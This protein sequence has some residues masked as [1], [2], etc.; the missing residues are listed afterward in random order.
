M[1]GR[2]AHPVLRRRRELAQQCRRSALRAAVGMALVLLMLAQTGTAA[3]D[4]S[5]LFVDRA[6]PNCSDA[7]SGTASQPFCT[8]G[9]AAQRVSAGQTVQVA[10]GSYSENVTVPTSGTATAPV[11]FTAA[12][13]ATVVLSGQASGFTISGRSWI[14]VTGFTVTG[15]SGYGISVTSSAHITL[16]GNH[17]SYSGH[18]VSG[19]T[20]SGIRL[21]NVTDSLVSRNTADHNTYA[22]IELNNGSTRNE[23]KDNVTFNNARGYE[24]A[25]PG[26]R[27][28][29]AP[30]NIVDGNVSHH[31]E[32]SG[33]EA[34]P[35][36][37]NSLIY[38]NVTYNNGDH[39]ID[40]LTCTGQRI[41]ANT[42]YKNVTAGIN[43]EGNSTGATLANNI[44]VDNGIKSP[45]THSDI[46]IEAGSTAGTTM[47]YDLVYLTTPDTILIWSSTSYSSLAA[48][49][50]ASGQE[51]HGIQADPRWAGPSAGD[52][53]LTAGSPAIDSANSGAS[54][55]PT[56]DTE[57]NARV[58]DPGTQNTGTGPRAYDDRGAY[59]L[60][61]SGPPP[62]AAPNA[63]LTVNPS[64]GVA[65]VQVTADASASTDEDATPI[66]TYTFDFGDGS[67]AVGPQAGATAT[68]T[69]TAPG[70]YTV[71]VTV[72]DTG[73]LS[74]TA[75]AGVAVSSS[76]AAPN[77]ALTVNPS[78]GAA[79]VQVTADA[80]AST[81]EDAT[82]IAT[83][84]FDFGDGS[85]AVGPQAGATA[86]H[87]YTAPGNYTA[88]VTVTDTGG[89]SSTATAQVAVT[90]DA[91]P[92]AA[93]TVTPGTGA[94]PLQV[95]ADA[96]ASRDGD[97]TPIATYT[98]DFGDGSPAVGP[99]A[100]AT[101][102]HTYTAPGNYTAT[103]T[104]TDT[105]GLSSTASAQ[106][107]VTGLNNL[108]GNPGFETDLSGWNTSGSGT[109]ISLARV[110][111]GHS[112][113]WAAMLTNAGSTASTCTLNDSPDWAK[114]T[115]A[116]TYTGSIWVRADTP[117]ATLKLRFR[118]YSGST[119][120]GTQ[121]TLA[122]LTTSWQQV[123]VAYTTQA[124]GSSTLDFNA[125]VSSAAP[126]S[127]FY[128]D[129]AEIYLG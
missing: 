94:A 103:V 106:V 116:G 44:S 64:T 38:N 23:V 24:R 28:Y 72:T 5:V 93:L 79:P 77:A 67:P 51:A 114:P 97:A 58:D 19:Q 21:G 112:G 54:G 111:G 17:V 29:A 85:P 2:R 60:Q 20:R 62:D 22:G 66:A 36:S 126:G 73:G 82:P 16:S 84:T 88:T 37:N 34:Y 18:P 12:P 39:G 113:G 11:T 33:I 89:L 55:Q 83:Y 41:I 49:R 101:A 65:P 119:L 90:S 92:D 76:D 31:N 46:R 68:H 63:A 27:L 70:S 110:A 71:S 78:T 48:F 118:E 104:V 8:V 96:S 4:G 75:T 69:Y 61:S 120:V 129:D 86:A 102:A 26:I 117:G 57:G 53:H 80:S 108:V 30:G 87:T 95:N 81:D 6:N 42:A 45:R 56:L 15:T 100:G 99:Q 115:S 9:A 123:T 40:D 125:Y 32:D 107:V 25:A 91:P 122:T 121:T 127:R 109:N 1:T 13:G 7:G 74:S 14:T 59:E 10:A 35:G 43:V 98:F 47:D 128:A 3:A 124:P 52:F 105:G 50:L